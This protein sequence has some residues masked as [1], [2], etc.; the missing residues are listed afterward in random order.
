MVLAVFV[1]CELSTPYVW[2]AVVTLNHCQCS[3]ISGERETVVTEHPSPKT[4]ELSRP[5]P[6]NF[7]ETHATFTPL[8]GNFTVN[9]P[10]LNLIIL[11][12]YHTQRGLSRANFIYFHF[13]FSENTHRI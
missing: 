1:H 12:M 10:S 13:I 2:T 8:L 11:L 4:P 9:Q 7:D 6:N 5:F 3:P